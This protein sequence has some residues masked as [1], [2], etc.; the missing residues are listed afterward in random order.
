MLTVRFGSSCEYENEITAKKSAGSYV[1][2]CLPLYFG[3]F[4]KAYDI[5]VYYWG[6]ALFQLG[7]L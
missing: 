5:Y 3:I 1:A 4:G 6:D 2:V 7:I